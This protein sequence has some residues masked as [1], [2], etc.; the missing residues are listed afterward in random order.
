MTLL[1]APSGFVAVVPSGPLQLPGELS[2]DS[3]DTGST[4]SGIGAHQQD[5][6]AVLVA[7]LNDA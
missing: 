3:S 6:G 7:V 2:G 4:I 5:A 1:T